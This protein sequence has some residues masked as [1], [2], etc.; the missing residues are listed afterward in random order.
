MSTTVTALLSTGNTTGPLPASSSA[1]VFISANYS[2]TVANAMT[3]LIT[4]TAAVDAYLV[5]LDPFTLQSVANLNT[6]S[7][8]LVTLFSSKPSPAALGT[9]LTTLNNAAAALPDTTQ[10][11]SDITKVGAFLLAGGSTATFQ[12]RFRGCLCMSL[13]SLQGGGA[14]RDSFHCRFR[15]AAL[16]C[17]FMLSVNA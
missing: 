14:C 2:T 5:A 16:A 10:M 17:G 4:Q 8:Q 6:F 1:L 12:V 15:C 3:Y 11:Q 13:A 7:K 9:L